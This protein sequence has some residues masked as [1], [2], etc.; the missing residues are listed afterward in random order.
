MLFKNSV[1]FILFEVLNKGIP[2]LLLPI[3][4]GYLSPEDFGLYASFTTFTA[5]IG[6][7]IGL[8]AQGSIQANYF[9]LSKEK[10]SI[11]IYNVLIVLLVALVI[12]FIILIFL[13]EIISENLNISFEWQV[14]ALIVAFSQFITLINLA[15]WVIEQKPKIYGAYQLLQSIT[16]ASL[17]LTLIIGYDYNWQGQVISYSINT[18]LFACGS[19]LILYKN[20]Y[21][22]LKIQ[23]L[24]IIDFL[25]FGIP[26]VPHQLGSWIQ[27]Q[28]DKIL[29][30]ALFGSSA[31]GLFSVGQQ[32]GMIMSV[33]IISLNK[34]LTPALYR[35]LNNELN[36]TNKCEIVK[37]T[38]YLFLGIILFG[39][40][41]CVGMKLVYPFILGAKFQSSLNITQLI[42]ISFIFSGM[43]YAVVGYIF[44][45][46]KTA[47]LARITISISVFHLILTYFLLQNYGIIG[48]AYALITSFCFHFLAVWHLSNKIYPMPWFSFWK[49]R[50]E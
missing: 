37:R 35:M 24:Y 8:S 7:F 29:I 23:K 1:I 30:M 40:L 11:Y 26:L 16:M 31:T 42:I 10:I 50:N 9:R 6:I 5:F 3:I 15:L 14:L 28:G 43:Y 13:N 33:V 18:I 34:A 25:K 12:S 27:G 2:F 17:T 20:G 39:L 41:L 19:L 48:S 32:V 44:Y 46:K 47:R 38:Y 36:F 49:E 22:Q 45:F 21:F 4:T